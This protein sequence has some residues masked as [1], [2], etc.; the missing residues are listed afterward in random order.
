MKEVNL[1]ERERT[2]KKLISANKTL[3]EDY[4]RETE[5]YH[6]LEDKYKD[7]LVQFNMVSKENTRNEQLVFGMST[8]G[9]IGNYRGY[10]TDN[11]KV[12]YPSPEKK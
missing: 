5:R 9:N 12:N 10:L 8:G 1:E 4:Q 6:L 7:V 3:R 2:I 11:E